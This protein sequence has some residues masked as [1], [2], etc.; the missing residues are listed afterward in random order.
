[1]LEETTMTFRRSNVEPAAVTFKKFKSF[2]LLKPP[3][4][5]SPASR[6]R[7]KEGV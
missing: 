5:S 1:M 3:P 6:G 2:E 7:M 4:V